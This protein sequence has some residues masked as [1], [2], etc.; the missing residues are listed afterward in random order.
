MES[1]VVSL[2]IL[3][4][5]IVTV[6]AKLSATGDLLILA[7]FALET[8]VRAW[9]MGIKL[10]LIDPFCGLDVTL[11]LVDVVVTIAAPGG[12]NVSGARLARALKFCKFLREFLPS[13][14]CDAH[15]RRTLTLVYMLLHR[16]PEE[17]PVHPRV[18]P[19]IPGHQA[20]C[21]QPWHVCSPFKLDG[22][23]PGWR[24]AAQGAAGIPEGRQPGRFFGTPERYEGQ[25]S[26]RPVMLMG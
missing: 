18:L 22:C 14:S 23:Q 20:T 24:A 17:C 9:A 16:S 7:A 25:L 12:T 21:H 19:Q 13:Q 3:A 2:V 6:V 5:V 1:I 8:A 4:L 10:Y 26:E 11:V 15:H